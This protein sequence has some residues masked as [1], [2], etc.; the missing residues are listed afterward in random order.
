MELFISRIKKFL[1]FSKK[2]FS[3]NSSNRIFKPKL[4]KNKTRSEKNYCIFSKKS[5]SYISENKR[6]S[7]FVKL[8]FVL[9]QEMGL[10]SCELKK[11]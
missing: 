11:F 4:E 9:F 8:N 3:Y 10:F 1:T 2:C 5:F 6:F 7:Y